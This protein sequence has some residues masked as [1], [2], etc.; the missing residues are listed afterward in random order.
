MHMATSIT[1]VHRLRDH[2]LYDENQSVQALR[3][4]SIFPLKPYF[5]SLAL[6][7]DAASF[8]THKKERISTDSK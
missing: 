4:D 7:C 6:P 1:D 2:G 8:Y 3:E 5:P